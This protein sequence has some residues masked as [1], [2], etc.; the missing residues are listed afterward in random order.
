MNLK[1]MFKNTISNEDESPKVR[2]VSFLRRLE[3]KR[4]LISLLVISAIGGM[5]TGITYFRKYQA[6]KAEPNIEAQKETRALVATVGKLMELPTDE[7]PTVATIADK[8]KLKDQPF[9][10][11]AEN[12]DKILAFTKAMQAI[13]YRPS[14]NKIIN[15][16]SILIDQ[17]VGVQPTKPSA[18]IPSGLK[19]SYYNGTETVGLS[20]QDEKAV[21]T[22]YSNYQTV[23]LGNASKKDYTETLVIDL[24]GT[25]AKE[26]GEIARLLK[27]RVSPLPEGE[28]KPDADILIISGK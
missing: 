12:G 8:E 18:Q 3:L 17:K 10:A 23:T 5:T 1:S 15:V 4:I 11:K 9:F 20:G 13:L 26:A 19:I 7:T 2:R 21:K 16:A 25:H 24:S 28:S 6:L 22:A 14:T 27:G